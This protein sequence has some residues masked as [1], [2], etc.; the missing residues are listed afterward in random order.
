MSRYNEIRELQERIEARM[1]AAMNIKNPELVDKFLT[2]CEED[3]SRLNEL[4]GVVYNR[5]RTM[6]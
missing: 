4:L 6:I 5:D 2:F 1:Q 3:E